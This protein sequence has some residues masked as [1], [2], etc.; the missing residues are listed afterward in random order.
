VDPLRL[1]GRRYGYW[2]RLLRAAFAHAGA[3]RL[4]HVMGLFRQF[5]IPAGR[6]GSD[7]AYVAYPAEALLGILAL[8]SLRHGAVVVGEDLGT[9]PPGLRPVLARLRILSSRVLYFE[10]DPGA[11]FLP[12]RCYPRRAL[13]TA[14]THDLPPLAGFWEARDLA[15]RRAAGHIP[16]DAALAEALRQREHERAAL[17][18]RLRVEGCLDG[19]GPDDDRPSPPRLCAAVNAFLCRTRSDLAG[20]ALDDLAGERE[21]VNLPGVPLER[22]PSW[23]RRMRLALEDLPHDAA[24]A[25]ALEG[26][27]TRARGGPGCPARGA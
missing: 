13:V 9:L 16:D 2:I 8:E 11:G 7:G 21:P 10:R 18:N 12:S 20:V 5:W 27:R 26:T 23:Q 22:Y 4:D 19:S 3:L 1:E 24:V 14:N 25:L 15:L 6:P 17:L